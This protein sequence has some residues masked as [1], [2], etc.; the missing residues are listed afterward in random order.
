[1]PNILFTQRCVRSCPYCFA[2][3]HMSD[4]SPDDTIS[5]ENLIYLADFLENSGEKAFSILG[6][7][8]TLH[9][10]FLDMVLY[11][12]ERRFDVRVFT[13]GVLSP[14]LVADMSAAIENLP[15]QRLSFI[16]NVNN[17]DQTPPG[18]GELESVHRFLEAFGERVVPG[19]NIY[20]PDFR[21]D[22]IFDYIN[23]YGLKRS[24]RL[25]LA[26]PIPGKQNLYVGLDQME[27]TIG[28]LFEYAPLF[29]RLRVA[30][31]LD[32]GFPL[33][34]FTDDQL[35]WFYR[36]GGNDSRFGCGP[37]L[38]IGPDMSL[39]QCFPLSGYHKRSVFEFDNL[40]Q[41]YEYYR[42]ITNNVRMESSGP[43]LNCDTCRYR[44]IGQCAG[45]C[46][47][48]MLNAFQDEPRIRVTEV[49]P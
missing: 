32:C 41:M 46:L 29:E 36:N 48:H 10:D 49:Y 39:W 5:W 9:P 22:F 27:A 13:S 17:P 34:K 23:R 7:E 25:G 35:L 44:E 21:L 37:V 19:F 38:D 8:P 4:S 12:I 18:S 31:G 24:V 14:R 33:C 15:M 2:K 28:R 1:M 26:H 42:N 45:G 40:E 43:F 20:H 11:L 47:A 16:C 6:G 3:K 30:P